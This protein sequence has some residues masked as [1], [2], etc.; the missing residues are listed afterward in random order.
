M[1]TQSLF[2]QVLGLL[3]LAVVLVW[4]FR[5]INLPPI[6]A[7]LFA[8]LL[9]GPSAFSWVADPHDLQLVAELGIVFLLFTLGLEFSVPKLWAMR[10]IVFVLGTLQVLATMLVT[11]VVLK[12]LHYSWASALTVGAI[13]ALSSTAIVI[14]QLAE[15]GELHSRKGQLTVG[16][17]LF[18][19]IAVVPILIVLPMLNSDPQQIGT[20]LSLALAKGIFVFIL[21]LAFGKWLLPRLFNAVAQVRTDELFVLTTL[22][23][24]LI[25]AGLTHAFGLSM[26][27]GAFLAGMMLGESQYRHQLEADIRPF[28]DIL[29]GLFFITVGAQLNVQVVVDKY[30]SLLFLIPLFVVGKVL[31]VR[32]LASFLGEK[33]QASWASGLMLAQMGEFSFVVIALGSQ[34]HLIDTEL[35]SMLIALGVISM[36][37]TPFIIDHHERWLASWFH[38][39]SEQGNI[40]HFHSELSDHVIVCGFGRVGQTVA[41]FLKAEAIPYIAL[42]V[43]PVRVA[44]SQAG[45]ENVQYGHARHIDILRAAGAE[46]AKLVMVT[47]GDYHRAESVVINARKLSSESVIVV[48]MKDD[49]KIEKLQ[50]LGATEVVP[51]TLE[52]SLM[53]VSQV[54]HHSGVPMARILKRINRERRNRYGIMH[55]FFPGESIDFSP[56]RQEK[57]EFLHAVAL[58]PNAFAV[59][60]ALSALGLEER[61]VEVMGLRRDGEE[62][63][64]PAL[65]TVLSAHDV[66]ILRG[67]PRRVERIERYLLEGD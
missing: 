36:A 32:F 6:L 58:M 37:L 67:K 53:L 48:R 45:G 31:V 8:G 10:N 59:G 51:E 15:R 23:V 44:E 13:F 27:L 11:A 29:M 57:L 2:V 60:K 63:L 42:D 46:R 38:D 50:S 64:Q 1:S 24:T 28:R 9:A 47:F 34:T 4:A 7:Y 26:A 19:D 55:G 41:R 25:A 54:L 33:P 65:E 5:R 62:L 22:L 49:S 21:L 35:A 3:A 66:L 52:A 18:Q 30:A 43:D 40:A 17:L 61:R 39:D 16:V 20:M 56:E 12:V 14:K